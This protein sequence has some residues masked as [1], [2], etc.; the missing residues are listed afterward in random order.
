MNHKLLSKSSSNSKNLSGF[1]SQR[2]NLDRT[3]SS[4]TLIWSGVSPSYFLSVMAFDSL[5]AVV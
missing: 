2:W 1:C 3:T 4:Q 5:R